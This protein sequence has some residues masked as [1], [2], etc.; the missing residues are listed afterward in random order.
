MCIEIKFDNYEVLREKI[1]DVKEKVDY[2]FFI[3]KN[4]EEDIKEIKEN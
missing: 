2:V 4:N 3:V 1:E